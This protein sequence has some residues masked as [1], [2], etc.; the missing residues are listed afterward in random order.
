MAATLES[1]PQ[2]RAA[3]A[4]SQARKHRHHKDCHCRMFER[5]FCNAADALWQHKLNRELETIAKASHRARDIPGE[6]PGPLQL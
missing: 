4:L 3:F 2:L 1:T 5:S 6:L